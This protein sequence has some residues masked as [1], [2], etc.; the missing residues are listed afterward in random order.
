MHRVCVG[1]F[2]RKSHFGTQH[3]CV[4]MCLQLCCPYNVCCRASGCYRFIN[5]RRRVLPGLVAKINSSR[6]QDNLPPLQPS[7]FP[8][9]DAQHSNSCKQQLEDNLPRQLL[10]E[11]TTS[12][13]QAV[14]SSTLHSAAHGLQLTHSGTQTSLTTSCYPQQV[15]L[16]QPG[17]FPLV[18]GPSSHQAQLPTIRGLGQSATTQLLAQPGNT[19]IYAIM[20]F[21]F[22]GAQTGS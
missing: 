7:R 5:A 21:G 22:C 9:D 12:C 19:H 10:P 14:S 16:W 6:E 17:Q 1:F 2:R 13:Q 18:A 8:Q 15:V 3:Q 11:N 20:L 4:C